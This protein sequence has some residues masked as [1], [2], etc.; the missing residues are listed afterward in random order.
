MWHCTLVVATK[1]PFNLLSFLFICV[2]SF[3]FFSVSA[4]VSLSDSSGMGDAVGDGL[5]V[6]LGNAVADGLAVGLGDG[7]N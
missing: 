5:A 6:G 7:K 4:F 3:F 2:L 1:R